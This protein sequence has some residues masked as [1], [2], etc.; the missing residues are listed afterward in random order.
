[1][2]VVIVLVCLFVG[3]VPLLLLNGQTFTNT[4]V[5]IPFFLVPIILC[6]RF[7]IDRRTPEDEKRAWRLATMLMALLA[8][9]VLLTLPSASRFQTAFNKTQAAIHRART[10]PLKGNDSGPW[11]LTPPLETRAETQLDF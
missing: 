6:A 10:T 1:M 4:L 7:A 5:A 11:L 9:I 2:R 3:I 8:I